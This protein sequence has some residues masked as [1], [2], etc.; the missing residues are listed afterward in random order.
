MNSQRGEVA[1]AT[2]ILIAVG[3]FLLAPI[4]F[5]NGN[6]F[7]RSA[8]P[9]NRRT[10]SAIS[11]K[12]IVEITNT[13]ASAEGP[14]SVRVDRSVDASK[15]V[16]DPKLTLS[17][18]IGR[19]VAGLGTWGLVYVFVSLAFFGGAPIVW[20]WKKYAGMKETMK[21]TVQAIRELDDD[22]YKRVAPKLSEKMDKKH[23]KVVD[24]LKAELN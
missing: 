22:T 23:K 7:D 3:T 2:V 12:D 6:P 11:G 14:V 13:V 10:A 18:R 5:K 20:L 4:L 21:R 8:D 9:S 1:T 17:Q 19:L 16:T 15:E 24:K